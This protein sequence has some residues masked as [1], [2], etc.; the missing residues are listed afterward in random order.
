[1]LLLVGPDGHQVRLEDQDVRCLED[2]IGEESMVGIEPLGDL[3]LIADAALEQSE[4]CY[5]GKQPCQFDDLRHVRLPPEDGFLGVEAQGHVVHG[6][7]EAA[8]SEGVG[9]GVA[10]QGVVVSNEIEAFMLGLQ[11]QV[12]VHRPEIVADVQPSRG[13][14]T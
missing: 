11:L 4:G 7:V 13:L 5:A 8:L 9:R 10:G 3:V 1:V 6:H 2:R 14:D 12:L